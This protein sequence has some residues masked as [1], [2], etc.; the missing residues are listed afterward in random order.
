MAT[1]SK[2][3]STTSMIIDGVAASEAIDSSGEILDVKGCDTSDF[4][5]GVGLLN[6][7]HRGDQAQGASGNDIVGKIIYSKKIYK[8]DDCEGKRQEAYWDHVKLPFIYIKARL[9][10]GAEHPGALALAAAIRDA[11]MHAEPILLRFS[12]EGTTLKKEGNRLLRTIGRKVALTFKPA[13]KSAISGLI[14]DPSG[15]KPITEKQGEKSLLSRL[16]EDDTSKSEA[17]GQQHL[18]GYEMAYNPIVEEDAVGLLKNVADSIRDL[19]LDAY[20]WHPIEYNFFTPID[21]LQKGEHDYDQL[22][23][24]LHLTLGANK[25]RQLRD[26]LLENNMQRVNERDPGCR[27]P[28]VKLLP[29]LVETMKATSLSAASRSSLMRSPSFTSITLRTWVFT[30]TFNVTTTSTLTFFV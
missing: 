12:I 28:S 3:T 13:N 5:N 21:D 18:G 26:F 15:P 1:P 30:T 24:P 9:Y 19:R 14:S 11:V 20:K 22:Y 25:L 27:N 10:D 6:Y 8:K 29:I 16:L 17:P 7:E 4:E 2:Q 23:A